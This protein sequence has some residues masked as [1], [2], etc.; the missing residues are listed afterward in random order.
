MGHSIVKAA[1][2]LSKRDDDVASLKSDI[3]TV[4]WTMGFGLAF[5]VLVFETL[6]MHQGQCWL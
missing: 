3:A 4:K 1:S 6:F 5:Q 2:A